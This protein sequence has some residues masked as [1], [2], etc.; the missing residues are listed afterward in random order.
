MLRDHNLP[1]VAIRDTDE[2]LR[3]RRAW[4]RGLGPAALKEFEHLIVRRARQLV[5]RLGEQEGAVSMGK[6]VN[7]FRCVC[8]LH[9]VGVGLIELW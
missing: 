1:L 3:R 7:Y 2:H 9:R 6:W 8:G 5:D 4:T